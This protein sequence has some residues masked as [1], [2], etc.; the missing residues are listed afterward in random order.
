[1]WA[2]CVLPGVVAVVALTV[3]G[4]VPAVDGAFSSLLV[5]VVT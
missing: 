5:G 3:V 4:D 1:M 2:G